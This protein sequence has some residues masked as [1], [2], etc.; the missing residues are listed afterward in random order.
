[1][2]KLNVIKVAG[3]ASLKVAPDYNK[4]RIEVSR[5]FTTNEEAYEVAKQNSLAIIAA[6]ESVKLD[7][8]LAKTH[9]FDVSENTKPKYEKGR[10]V[11]Y[12]KNGY[13]LRQVL[14]I[15]MPINNSI[16]NT[17][18]KEIYEHVPFVEIKF[19]TFVSEPRQH[20]LKAL[21]LAVE[22]AKEKAEIIASSL[23]CKLGAIVEANYGV[24][25]VRTY[26]DDCDCECS[27]GSAPGAAL[28]FTGQE[29]EFEQSV[30]ITW[31]LVN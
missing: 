27:I 16:L 10:Y 18:T 23:G 24:G 4:I 29:Q 31:Q 20:K 6:L 22:D 12:V 14:F 30:I 25:D 15:E 28:E 13:D 9:T 1:M 3:G 11:G 8:S 26:Y 21:S 17:L 2:E 5:V 19:D 7:G